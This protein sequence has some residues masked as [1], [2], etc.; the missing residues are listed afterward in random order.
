[1]NE[2]ILQHNI[3]YWFREDESR[4]LD[5]CDIEH[6]EEQIKEGMVEGELCQYDTKT[7]ETFYG[8]WKILKDD[9]PDN[10]NGYSRF[11]EAFKNDY[12]SKELDLL[13]LHIKDFDMALKTLTDEERGR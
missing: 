1:M 6:I 4:Q 7:D 12:T 8:W 3:D 5:E 9:T 11:Y 2:I 13:W 10:A